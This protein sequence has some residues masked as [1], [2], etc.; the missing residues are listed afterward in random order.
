VERGAAWLPAFELS[1]ELLGWAPAFPLGSDFSER[2]DPD[3]GVLLEAPR[4]AALPDPLD[5][6]DPDDE[7]DAEDEDAPEDD[8]PLVLLPPAD[9]PPPLEDEPPRLCCPGANADT[10]AESIHTETA[11]AVQ[12]ANHREILGFMARPI[13]TWTAHSR[14]SALSGEVRP[15][16]AVRGR[17]LHEQ[18]DCQRHRPCSSISAQK[19]GFAVGADRTLSPS[20]SKCPVSLT[21]R[22]SVDRVNQ[23]AGGATRSCTRLPGAQVH[24]SVSPDEGRCPEAWATCR[25]RVPKDAEERQ[26]LTEDRS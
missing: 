3:A 15:A 14:R 9:D 23:R 12:L 11:T 17:H 19:G 16:S 6:A 18:P 22:S 4:G 10:G 13:L 20:G 5:D 21:L 1:P 7:P 26:H 2:D 8:P 24:E 25:G